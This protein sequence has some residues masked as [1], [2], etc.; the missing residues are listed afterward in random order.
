MEKRKKLPMSIKDL[1]NRTLQK[2]C[3]V[4]VNFGNNNYGDVKV[5]DC[6]TYGTLY[7]LGICSIFGKEEKEESKNI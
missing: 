6:D 7:F 5:L 1:Y 2:R 4:G 3:K